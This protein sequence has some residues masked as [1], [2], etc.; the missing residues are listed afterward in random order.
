MAASH[1]PARRLV[2]ASGVLALLS[3][4]A[5]PPLTV[6]PA[7]RS[8]L[9]PTGTLRI[10]VYLGSPTSMVKAADGSERGVTV[11]LGRALAHA[12][13]VPVQL[14][15]H[16]RV[17]EI[18]ESMKAGRVDVT[19]TNASPA[20]A[21]EVDFTPTVLSLESG[22]LVPAG[23]PL[24]DAAE[25]DRPGHR[26]GVTQGSTSQGV[27]TRDLRQARVVA[28]ASVPAAVAMLR[29]GE[30]HAYATNKA[31][32]FDMSDQLPGSRVLSGH[33][34]LEHL[35][36]AVPQGRDAAARAWLQHFVMAAGTRSL[37]LESAGRA[38]LRGLVTDAR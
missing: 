16:T 33:W 23:S 2:L 26:V 12:L 31:I 1:L 38:G 37:V 14:V 34:A 15:L 7:V 9:A 32:L 3:A 21:R 13:G 27:L 18:I 30:L 20:R 22:Y 6:D 4:C 36:L 24:R 5:S 28:A 29:A 10:G 8:A 19:L 11:E 35:A 17:P 25:V